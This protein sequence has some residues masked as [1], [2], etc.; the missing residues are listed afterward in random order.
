VIQGSSEH[1]ATQSRKASLQSVRQFSGQGG[2]AL[3]CEFNAETEPRHPSKKA[4]TRKRESSF[5]IADSS[6]VFLPLL[7]ERTNKA[8][9]YK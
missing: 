2:T 3:A 9:K 8:Q 7:F 6:N 5:L 1:A 4:K